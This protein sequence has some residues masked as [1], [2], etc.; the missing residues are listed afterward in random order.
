M[1]QSSKTFHND[2]NFLKEFLKSFHQKIINTKDFN[3]FENNLIEWIKNF[4]NKNDDD[5]KK[6][7]K[8]ILELM[9][10]HE[11]NKF[12]FSSIIG[13]FYQFGIGCDIDK[14]KALE[15]YLLIINYEKNYFM[16]LFLKENDDD[17]DEFNK[18]KK[19]NIIIGK[20]L[21]SLFYYKDIILNKRNLT[22]NLKRSISLKRSSIPIRFKSQ[23]QFDLNKSKDNMFKK[24]IENDSKQ[25]NSNK[26]E[27]ET[28]DQKEFKKFLKSAEKDVS[29]SQ[30]KENVIIM[31]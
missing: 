23:N 17:D 1:S 7:F 21:L 12:W 28:E 15:S 24:T 8:N 9:K 3:N 4:N 20:Y 6:N 5:D 29:E 14:N 11:Q 25:K 16:N 30:Y 19:L 10:N 27:I 18:L 26:N 22:N 2:E 31:E 13:Y